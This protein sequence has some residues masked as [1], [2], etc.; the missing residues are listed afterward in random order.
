MTDDFVIFAIKSHVGRNINGNN[1]ARLEMFERHAQKAK[2]IVKM[3]N[4]IHKKN[5]VV[6][7]EQC[8][9]SI[10]NVIKE[11]TS[12][13]LCRHFQGMPVKVA[14]IYRKRQ[15]TLDQLTDNPVA[16]PDLQRF[17]DGILYSG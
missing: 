1:T 17:L 9:V 8:R 10:K 3:L 5:K 2:I 15:V 16:T 4:D 6:G 12:F 11:E 7:F 13:A 14:S